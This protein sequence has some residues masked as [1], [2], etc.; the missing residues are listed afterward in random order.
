VPQGA[1]LVLRASNSGAPAAADA[2]A[3]A[4]EH[5]SKAPHMLAEPLRG[6]KIMEGG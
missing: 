2:S 4:S 6:R 5:K 1:A 3:D